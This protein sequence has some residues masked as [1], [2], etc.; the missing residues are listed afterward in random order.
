MSRK[1]L[2]IEEDIAPN[3]IP[4]IDIMFL[5]LL[6]FMLGADMGQRDLEAVALPYAQSVKEDKEAKKK[7]KGRI[8]INVFHVRTECAA[9]G[10][11]NVCDNERHWAITIRGIDYADPSKLETYL[12]AQSTAAREAAPGAESVETKVMIRADGGA[13]YGYVQDIM[14]LCFSLGIYQIECGAAKPQEHKGK[15]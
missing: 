5:L 13:P 11:G 4:M 3:L 12:K 9:H 15:V 2:R 1:V 6:F 10:A 7:D 14:G 8:T